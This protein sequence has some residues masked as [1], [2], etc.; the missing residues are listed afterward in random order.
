VD[1]VCHTVTISYPLRNVQ[2]ALAIARCT[3][4]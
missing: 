4:L 2:R 1:R 3:D